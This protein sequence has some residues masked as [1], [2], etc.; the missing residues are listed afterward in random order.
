MCAAVLLAG[1]PAVLADAPA[2]AQQAVRLDRVASGLDQVEQRLARLEADVDRSERIDASPPPVFARE[3][4][5]ILASIDDAIRPLRGLNW[6]VADAPLDRALKLRD[7]ALAVKQRLDSWPAVSQQVD[8]DLPVVTDA[9]LGTGAISGDLTDEA[10]GDPIIFTRVRVYC[11][12]IGFDGLAI[13]DAT[14]HY[15]MNGLGTGT[16]YV[17]TMNKLGYLDELWDDIPCPDSYCRMT[18]GTPIAVTDGSETTGI[19]FAL[20]KAGGI[21]GTVTDVA[22]GDPVSG[23]D[24]MVYNDSG[25]YL[26]SVTTGQDGVYVIDRLPAGTYYART[27]SDDYLDELWDDILCNFSCSPTDGTP[28]TVS[29]GSLTEGIDFALQRGGSISGTVTD[30][31]TGLPLSSANVSVYDASGRNLDS[32]YTAHDGT[33]TVT[34]LFAGQYFVR[35]SH[36]GYATELYDDIICSG[37]DPTTGTPVAVTTGGDTSGIDAALSK[38]STVSGHVTSA[39]SGAPLVNAWIYL[40][41]ASGNYLSN[42]NTDPVGAYALTARYPGTYH[43]VAKEASHVNELYDD[44]PCQPSCDPTA[45][46]PIVVNAHSDTPGIDF[47]LDLGGSIRGTVTDAANGAPLQYVEVTVYDDSGTQVAV[48]GTGSDGTYTVQGLLAGNYFAVATD[49]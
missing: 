12:N 25:G 4:R 44:I 16:C 32:T 40:Y 47:A 6:R 31:D 23:V 49:G 14:G 43:V 13:S 11:P 2:S 46:D 24:V 34:D 29:S 19:D 3:A 35:I 1:P 28:I 27:S 22:T 17:R 15:V 36:Y 41:D 33:Y 5:R 48:T 30:E 21:R 7:R 37:C 20:E 18:N 38:G 9:G 39:G 8:E 42:T 45:G 10:T 26:G